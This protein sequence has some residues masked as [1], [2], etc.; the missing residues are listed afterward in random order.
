MGGRGKEEGEERGG[1]GKDGEAKRGKG[2]GERK[3]GRREGR[4][5]LGEGTGRGVGV[6]VS[7]VPGCL[8]RVGYRG[9][10]GEEEQGVQ[11]QAVPIPE[12][13]SS[14]Q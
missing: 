5:G 8:G 11:Q 7:V 4:G 3:W 10:A 2:S 6:R 13:A 14:V 9:G 12:A 1:E